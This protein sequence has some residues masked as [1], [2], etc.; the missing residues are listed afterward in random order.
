MTNPDVAKLPVSRFDYDLPRHLIAQ[1][2]AEP[3]DSSRL[4]IVDRTRGQFADHR[5]LDLPDLLR[6][7]D[8]VILND[9]R[10]IPARLHARRLSGGRVEFLLLSRDQ[11]GRWTALARPAKRLR[12][13]ERLILLNRSGADTNDQIIVIGRREDS[14][15]VAFDDELAIER[16]GE[17]PL[18]PYIHE[19]L[20]NDDRYQTVYAANDGSA[21]APTAG[22]HFTERVFSACRERGVTFA[23]VTLHVGLDTFQPIK[24]EDASGHPMHSEWY[25]VPSETAE[26]VRATKAE[27]R[28]VIA[29]GTTSVRTLE[30]ASRSIVDGSSTDLRG[31]TR[32]FV[33]P[34]YEFRIVDALLTNFH[35]PRTTLMLLVSALADEQL[36]REAYAHAIE[37]RYRFLSFGDAM[38]IV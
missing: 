6:P 19:R 7:G 16:V 14:V 17:A 22:L 5:F 30:S 20:D 33:T 15:I 37:Q 24:T 8:L 13:G 25:D 31:A 23:T 11:G 38:L 29:V 27:G 4:L 35:L 12:D 34:G 1:T 36:I 26:L 21:A 2:P 18:P 32:L 10:V 3:R 28:R 9:T